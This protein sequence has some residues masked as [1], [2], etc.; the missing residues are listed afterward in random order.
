MRIAIVHNEYGRFSGEEAIVEQQAALLRGRGHEV[1]RFT[2]NSAELERS[3]FGPARA[4]F[5]GVYNPFS[6]KAFAAFL[7]RERPD[8][9]HVHNL[10][11]LI[12]PSI[13]PECRKQGVPVVMTVHNYRLVCPNGLFFSRGEVCERCA[14]GREFWCVLRNC[15]NSLPKSIGYALRNSVA[16]RQRLFLDSVTRYMALTE[17]QRRKLVA[18]GFPPDRIDVVPNAVEIPFPPDPPSAGPGHFV[19]YAG[20][21]SREKGMDVIFAAARSLPQIPF[22]VAGHAERAGDLLRSLPANVQYLGQLPAT[23]VRELY[24]NARIV[25]MASR[26]YEGMPASILEAMSHGKPVVA[27]R[28]GGI[29]E[30]VEDGGTG[31]LFEPGNARDLAERIRTLYDDPARCRTLG[32]A[33]RAR[34][35]AQYGPEAHCD[36]IIGVYGFARASWIGH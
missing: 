9:V 24:R 25:V 16:R 6:R 19:M 20:R 4:F 2:R 36:R 30:I 10:F 7:R 33:G 34:A 23:E 3:A 21:I 26:C 11:P 14:G 15:E 28:Q 32:T 22:K 5:S 17:F 1:I 18:A 31:L 29:P 13:L 8:V 12:S 27:P 35:A